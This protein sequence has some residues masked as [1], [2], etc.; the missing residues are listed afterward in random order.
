MNFN[1]IPIFNS[2][3][4][5]ALLSAM[6]FT[7][8]YMGDIGSDNGFKL[9][10][11]RS[12][13]NTSLCYF[14]VSPVGIVSPRAKAREIYHTLVNTA[15]NLD[16]NWNDIVIFLD[17]LEINGVEKK[18]LYRWIFNEQKE[19]I[20]DEIKEI[21]ELSEER[22][23]IISTYYN[24]KFSTLTTSAL[25]NKQKAEISAYAL[26]E[27]CHDEFSSENIAKNFKLFLKNA[28]KRKKTLRTTLNKL[29]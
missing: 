18:H 15:K 2:N 21:S 22:K 28:V 8:N 20:Q 3:N 13:E 17:L 7:F 5:Q 16:V 29:L 25:N 4:D 12:K 11:K 26:A 6:T 1:L 10:I 19:N 24:E 23:E 27:N 9:Y 14:I